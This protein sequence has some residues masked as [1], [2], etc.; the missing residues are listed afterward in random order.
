VVNAH[1]VT[2]AEC[3]AVIDPANSKQLAGAVVDEPKRGA[4][5]CDGR[6]SITGFITSYPP[7]SPN[8]GD[9]DHGYFAAQSF[10][11][12]GVNAC[13]ADGS[14]RFIPETIGYG[15]D[16]TQWYRYKPGYAGPSES[17]FGPWGALGSMNGG[18]STTL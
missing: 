14:G 3:L 7:N 10:H 6:A 11:T 4:F 2:P 12:G 8:C 9:G 1:W 18:E 5:W 16:L 15:N 13:L 17:I